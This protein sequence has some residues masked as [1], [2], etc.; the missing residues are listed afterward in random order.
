MSIQYNDQSDLSKTL[1]DSVD[2]QEEVQHDD[3]TLYE[4]EVALGEHVT[5][6]V[7]QSWRTVRR[8]LGDVLSEG[9]HPLHQNI[10]PKSVATWIPDQMWSE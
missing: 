9:K 8:R 3:K 4:A 5:G 2:I 6:G 10:I 1:S 7:V